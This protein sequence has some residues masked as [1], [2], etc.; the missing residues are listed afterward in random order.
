MFSLGQRKEGADMCVDFVSESSQVT[1][2]IPDSGNII[3]GAN[4]D[5]G[6]RKDPKGCLR[7]NIRVV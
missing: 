5:E 2:L 7:H 4:S 3:F 6:F 1:L